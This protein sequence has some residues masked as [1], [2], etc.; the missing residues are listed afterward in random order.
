MPFHLELLI[1]KNQNIPSA[2]KVARKSHRWHIKCSA[3]EMMKKRSITDR[4]V[5]LLGYSRF[6]RSAVLSEGTCVRFV[7]PSGAIYDVPRAYLS[8]WFGTIPLPTPRIRASRV[9]ADGMITRVYFRGGHS[10]DVAWDTVLMACEPAYEHF[11]GLT[12]ESRRL[13]KA[14][15]TQYGNFR[16]E[17]R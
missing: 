1:I 17:E 10:V 13:T 15:I 7:Y 5:H 2:G 12:P 4:K 11:G 14:G 8:T 16:K 6:K 9:L 3:K